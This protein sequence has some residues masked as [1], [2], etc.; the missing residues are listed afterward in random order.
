MVEIEE[1]CFERVD[2][3]HF[4]VTHNEPQGA[5][6]ASSDIKSLADRL[7]GGFLSAS[8][9]LVSRLDVSRPSQG[10]HEAVIYSGTMTGPLAGSGAAVLWRRRDDGSW[11]ESG[12]IL[13]RW[14]N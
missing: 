1:W 4:C 9:S 2:A 12:E 7:S 10:M 14:T 5:A 3:G 8:P 6:G 13:I 11:A